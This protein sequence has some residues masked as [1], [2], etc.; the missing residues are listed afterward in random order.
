MVQHLRKLASKQNCDVFSLS[1]FH[2]VSEN[3][4]T[5]FA[6]SFKIYAVL[7]KILQ[8]QNKLK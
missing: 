4:G 2:S 6:C 1:I 5:C 3:E 8:T 7:C